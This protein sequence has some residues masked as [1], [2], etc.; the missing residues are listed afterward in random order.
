MLNDLCKPSNIYKLHRKYNTQSYSIKHKSS[1]KNKGRVYVGSKLYFPRK[2]IDANLRN[3]ILYHFVLSQLE[4]CDWSF[5]MLGEE[6]CT[7]NFELSVVLII[8]KRNFIYNK[9]NG[10][11]GPQ[12]STGQ[13]SSSYLSAFS[14]IV[15]NLPFSL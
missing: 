15:N 5:Y 7:F 12:V 4:N 3:K 10:L 11:A 9:L 1:F 2:F 6:Y 13:C 14:F 8:C